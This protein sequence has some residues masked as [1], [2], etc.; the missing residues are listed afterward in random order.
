MEYFP[1]TEIKHHEK[2]KDFNYQDWYSKMS[3][4]FKLDTNHLEIENDSKLNYDT[5]FKKLNRKDKIKAEYSKIFKNIEITENITQYVD[6]NFFKKEFDGNLTKLEEDLNKIIFREQ[7]EENTKKNKKELS[8]NQIHYFKHVVKNTIEKIINI[9]TFFQEVNKLESNKD[10]T[11]KILEKAGLKKLTKPYAIY[12]NGLYFLVEISKEDIVD[13]F[14]DRM[15]ISHCSKEGYS[16]ISI[17]K[18]MP[19][20][21]KEKIIIHEIR[22]I[23]FSIH[24]QN[25][26]KYYANTYG[27]DLR[28]INNR[29]EISTTLL[30]KIEKELFS[31]SQDEVLA[32]MSSYELGKFRSDYNIWGYRYKEFKI[33]L[34]EFVEEQ[35]INE[36][37]KKEIYD[38]YIER[39]LYVNGICKKYFFLVEKLFFKYQTENRSMHEFEAIIRNIPPQKYKRLCIFLGV[40]PDK[41]EEIYDPNW[42]RIEK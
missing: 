8:K 21:V 17:N 24:N 41:F 7:T 33:K 38:K 29:Q 31:L 40:D 1:K 2:S 32:Y 23:I 42:T 19:S 4:D 34:D 35:K 13:N 11:F 25:E 18:D 39:I 12:F 37:D 6:D 28:A 26:N 30:S 22:H 20:D 9:N 10:K 3:E 14:G 5:W 15:A 16:T 36:K 27:K